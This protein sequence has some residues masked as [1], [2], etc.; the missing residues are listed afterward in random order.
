MDIDE[1]L[2]FARRTG[3]FWTSAEIYGGISGLFDYGHLGA[4][5]KRRFEE[6]WLSFFVYEDDN[7]HLIDGST[8]LSERPLIAS[9]HASRFNDVIIG[10]SSCKAY[11]RTD[12]LLN[13][14]G[15][16]VSEGA[17]A[18][19]LSKAIKDNNVKC[20]KCKETLMEPK[21]FNM[22]IN[23]QL[24]P[25]KHDNGF[26][27]PETAQSAYLNFFREFNILR[28]R[29]PMG[30]AIIGRAYRNEIS[31]RQGLYRMRELVQAE[32]QIF[33]DPDKWKP[34]GISNLLERNVNIM[35]Y[36]GK[37]L[38]T[39]SGSALVSDFGIPEFYAYHMCMVDYFY[40]ELLHVPGEKLRFLEL[41][42]NEKA[43]YNKI[44]F[45]IEVNVGSWNGFKEVGGIHY[46]GDYDLAS[47][48]K[49]SGQDLSVSIDGKRFLPHVLELSFG[50]DRNI[51]MLLDLF[52]EKGEREILKLPNRLAPYDLAVFPL[53]S[54]EKLQSYARQLYAELK[55][56]FRA[57][58]DEG[59]S[60]GKRYA[61]MD[62]VGT[63]LCI[64]VDYETIESDSANKD[65][66]TVRDRDTKQQK[67]VNASGIPAFVKGGTAGA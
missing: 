45:D 25:E 10:C 42:G 23:V 51:W 9:G 16:R 33:F 2:G 35:P 27:R 61:R 43:F 31:P 26:L 22:M 53:Q 29:L 20:P 19:E 21:A 56:S 1:L 47:H 7:Y 6:L 14:L 38:R 40:K 48:T 63:P 54:D 60:I 37:E 8:M 52:Y 57:Y 41:G 39:V 13:E 49:G 50:V 12:V 66:V 15:I 44:H 24:G 62:E 11:Y 28:K 34:A 32:L 5:L 65:T 18:D 30:L 58:Y 36:K 67:R 4:A 3:F 64:T 17:T 46:R 59:G 55:R